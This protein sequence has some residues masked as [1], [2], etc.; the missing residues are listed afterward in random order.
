MHTKS[1]HII[2]L[3]MYGC[4]YVCMDGW[5]YGWMD[6]WMDVWMDGS[7]DGWMSINSDI[8]DPFRISLDPMLSH[9]S[10]CSSPPW[11]ID[12][13]PALDWSPPA[14]SLPKAGAPSGSTATMP[15]VEAKMPRNVGCWAQAAAK[16]QKYGRASTSPDV[17]EHHFKR[18]QP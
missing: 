12:R 8:S 11:H 3:S 15:L 4:M 6:V 18:G 7:M 14:A 17:T 2:S 16:K 1:H 13:C 9:G 5:M 10:N